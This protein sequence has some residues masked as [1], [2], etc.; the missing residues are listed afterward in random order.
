MNKQLFR[1]GQ[2][3]KT[4]PQWAI[5]GLALILIIIVLTIDYLIKIN[6][7]CDLF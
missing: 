7:D 1:F 4:L 2:E 5:M 3:L 6:L